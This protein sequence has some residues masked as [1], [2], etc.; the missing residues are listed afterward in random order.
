MRKALLTVLL[1]SVIVFVSISFMGASCIVGPGPGPTTYSLTIINDSGSTI[2]ILYNGSVYW[3]TVNPG[4]TYWDEF[5][6]VNTIINAQYYSVG[7]W[8]NIQ[9]SDKFPFSMPYYNKTVTVIS[10]DLGISSGR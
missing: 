9:G 1:V 7:S 2:R 6:P 4:T 5:V 3:S 10:S 8:Y